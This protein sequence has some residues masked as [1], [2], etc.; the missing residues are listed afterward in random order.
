[1]VEILNGAETGDKAVI[2]PNRLKDGVKIKI[3]E[4]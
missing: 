3:A 2:K 4:K 1:M